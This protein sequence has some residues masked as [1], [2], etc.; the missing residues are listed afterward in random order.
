MSP[1]LSQRSPLIIAPF[2]VCALLLGYKL[3]NQVAE[4]GEFSFIFP[5]V[6][7]DGQPVRT[8]RSSSPD[9]LLACVTPDT[10]DPLTLNVN[11]AAGYT[12]PDCYPFVQVV[13]LQVPRDYPANMSSTGFATLSILQSVVTE[14]LTDGWFNSSLLV[15]AAQLPFLQIALTAALNSVTSSGQTL[16]VTL[17]IVWSTS[18]SVLY[19]GY[20]IAWLGGVCTLL[21]LCAFVRYR[22]DTRLRASSPL[23]MSISLLG[24]LFLYVALVCIVA[25][26]STWSCDV[27][28]WLLQ[29]GYTLT[30]A[31]LLAKAYRIY[32]IFGRKRLRVL[33]S[34]DR[35]LLLF[36]GAALAID[37]VM[38]TAAAVNTG[39]GLLQPVSFTILQSS[40]L[41]QHVY[42][43]CTP[44]PGASTVFVLEAIIKIGMLI[45]GVLLAFATRGVAD[46]F[47]ESKSMAFVV[48]NVVLVLLLI[49][50]VIVVVGAVGDTMMI[51]L[52]LLVAWVATFTLG[53]LF[54][55]KLAPFLSRSPMTPT[56]PVVHRRSRSSGQ[57][58]SFLPLTDIASASVLLPYL[59]ALDKHN[60]ECKR[61]LA[62]LR[63]KEGVTGKGGVAPIT[64]LKL[65]AT[66]ASAASVPQ[67]LPGRLR[68]SGSSEKQPEQEKGG[69]QEQR[70][71]KEEAA[72]MEPRLE[73]NAVGLT[74]DEVSLDGAV[75]VRAGE[76]RV[77]TA[78]AEGSE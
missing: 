41:R 17:P 8:A 10:F 45:A 7:S 24:I 64:P 36:V 35:Q 27:M 73:V 34:T 18:R 58:F 75:Q 61:A 14:N 3:D 2:F 60:A 77:G 65:I 26:P 30:F 44:A 6:D 76:R 70:A 13:Y 55:A 51:L 57:Q 25:Q 56:S 71:Q 53:S 66:P 62:A 4:I 43:A 16:L 29:L 52:L 15:R 74:P 12:H 11:A 23:I 5:G 28:G 21:T 54:V 46:E 78:T 32:R 1:S 48:Y 47:N 63:A 72:V 19:S 69:E 68:M 50:P 39:N 40:D 67:L 22:R 49:V 42:S 38:L 33:R 20:A 31:P 37:V 59:R 9:G